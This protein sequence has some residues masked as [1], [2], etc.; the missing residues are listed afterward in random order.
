MPMTFYY[1]R[2][3]GPDI[4]KNS[5]GGISDFRIYGQSLIK[6]NCH[7]WR[8]SDDIEMKLKPVTKIDKGNKITSKTFVDD[9][10]L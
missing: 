9:V 6:G 4:G 2:D 1:I 10:I 3:V 7:N 8:T 5:E